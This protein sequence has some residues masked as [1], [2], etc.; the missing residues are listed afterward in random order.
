VATV[1]AC[2]VDVY[3]TLIAYD[4]QA[5]FRTIAAL[6]RVDL[7]DLRRSQQQYRAELDTGALSTAE[8]FSR[9]L[10][11]CG[12]SP[13]PEL[14]AAV[15]DPRHMTASCRLYDDALPFL[16]MLRSLGISIALV[17]NC[18]D[19]TRTMLADLGLTALADH[20]TLS[21]E[22]GYLKPSPQIY[23]H[24]LSALEIPP[25]DAVMIDDQAG[26][27]AGAEEAGVRAIHLARDGQS[28]RSQFQTVLSL[29]NV[30]PLL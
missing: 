14:V 5:R 16:N 13:T 23:A 26:Y 18:P 30:I 10:A 6:A 7:D 21:C 1:R 25:Q 29:H 19:N 2:L 24:P 8:A 17:S 20:V 11:A 22:V 3:E 4:F 28:P 15:A 9:S 27:C 12:A